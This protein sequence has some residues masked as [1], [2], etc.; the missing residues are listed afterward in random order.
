[1][2]KS[3]LISFI[4]ML[5]LFLPL[6]AAVRNDVVVIEASE[7]VQNSTQEIAKDYLLHYIYPKKRSYSRRLLINLKKLDEN[8]KLIAINTKAKKTKGI[9]SYFATQK[10]QVLTLIKE[11]PN[12]DTVES[13]IGFS[14]IFSE[15]AKS[16]MHHHIYTFSDEETM[17]M[18][19]K[20]MSTLLG[21][22]VKYYAA[23]EIIPKNKVYRK[24]IENAMKKFEKDL[25]RINQYRYSKKMRIIQKSLNKSWY[26]MKNYL[27]R[28]DEVK[29]PALLSLAS[30][31]M[32]STLEIFSIYHS[33]NQ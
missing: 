16:I 6:E 2:I 4:Y 17:L 15:G 5:S 19:T 22:M 30:E 25:Q 29:V 32:Q 14:E 9:L 26:V 31:R 3:I 24:K 33:K 28:V 23:I 21:S 8:I 11:K 7:G 27:T 18:L 1:M 12:I 10:V 13:M 20:E